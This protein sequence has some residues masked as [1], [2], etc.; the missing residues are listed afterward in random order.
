MPH[1]LPPPHVLNCQRPFRLLEKSSSKNGDGKCGK[2]ECG[3]RSWGEEKSE[4]KAPVRHPRRRTNPGKWRAPAPLRCEHSRGHKTWENAKTGVPHQGLSEGRGHP[5]HGVRGSSTA[6]NQ[7]GGPASSL[8][9][10]PPPCSEPSIEEV[11]L[12]RVAREGGIGKKDP[13][14]H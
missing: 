12:N 10:H 11:I 1:L 5:T 7:L 13:G 3:K 6:A 14:S 9:A 2:I 8:F 4:R